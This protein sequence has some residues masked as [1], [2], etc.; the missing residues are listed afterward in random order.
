MKSAALKTVLG[1]P[2]YQIATKEV[3]VAVTQ[4]GGHLGPV[5]FL[6]GKRAVKPFS[7]APWH[8]EKL[9]SGTPSI[10][11]VLRGDFF[12]LPFGGNEKTFRGEQHPAHGETANNRWRFVASTRTK[13]EVTLRL[14]MRTKIRSS[15]IEK[16][17]LLVPGQTVIYQEHIINGM[18][19]PMSM[20]HHATLKFPDQVGA[21]R[22]STSALIHRQVYVEPTESPER[23]GY[24]ILKPGA[25][26][27]DLQS[28]PTI[29]G[30]FAD[31]SRYPAR[32]GFEDIAILV[33]DPK[34]SVAWTAVAFVDEGYV[35]FSLRD[36]RVLVSTLL[37]MSN[38]GR[39]YPPWSSRH[40]NVMG[41][42][43]ITSFFHSGLAE[44]AAPN[45]LSKRGLKTHHVL[46]SKDPFSVRYIMGLAAIP[47]RFGRVCDIVVNEK[48][49]TL[50]GA[51]GLKVSTPANTR[52]LQGR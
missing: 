7:V 26:F 2:S 3:K 8:A 32:R 23:L 17:I 33:A 1:Q 15:L 11:R 14:S 30:E 21:A 40:I 42:E 50:V 6:L 51:T 47:K 48:S 27:D 16:R 5:T 4:I 36:P 19:G 9:P 29:T 34:L 24:S 25:V 43:D 13:S 20:G 31:L 46:N 44:S 18:S 41:L 49:V 35:W 12:C 45:P 52:F 10:L 38:G 37:W 39:H 22:I 28:V